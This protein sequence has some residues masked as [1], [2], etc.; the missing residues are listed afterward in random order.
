MKRLTF[1]LLLLAAALYVAWRLSHGPG[2]RDPGLPS[3][4]D[5]ARREA[6]AFWRDVEGHIQGG[7]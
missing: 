6:E 4:P 7:A 5:A 2:R 3:D 1:L